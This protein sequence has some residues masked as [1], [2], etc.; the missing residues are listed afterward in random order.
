MEYLQYIVIHLQYMPP[1]LISKK[2]EE[3]VMFFDE[4]YSI[5]TRAG[6]LTPHTPHVFER[7]IYK[8]QL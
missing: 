1:Q 4:N 3:T 8:T 7:T 6:Y 5:C 2:N